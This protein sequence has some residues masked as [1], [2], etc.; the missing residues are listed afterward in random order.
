MKVININDMKYVAAPLI[1]ENEPC[2]GCDLKV[3]DNRICP[4]VNECFDENDEFIL[5]ELDK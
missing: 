3:D 4:H 2:T 5:V 1:D